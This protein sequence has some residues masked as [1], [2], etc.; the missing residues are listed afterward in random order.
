MCNA[1]P[2]VLIGVSGKQGS[3]TRPDHGRRRRLWLDSPKQ[4]NRPASLLPLL[5]ESRKLGALLGVAVVK[6][7]ISQGLAGSS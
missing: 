4:Q 6:Q 2:T 7:A 5:S 3:F 1:R